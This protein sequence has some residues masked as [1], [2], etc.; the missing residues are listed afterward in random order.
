MNNK[1]MYKIGYGLYILT[2]RENSYQNGCV[3]NTCMQVTTTPN[4]ISITVNKQN[5]THDMIKESGEFNISVIS[6]KATFDLFKHFGF[7]SGANI[8]KFK[9]YKYKSKSENGIYYIT[10]FCNAFISGKVIN[11]VDLGTHTMFIA[12]VIDGDVL[13]DD[14][15]VTYEYYQNNIKPKPKPEEKHI[16]G[17]RCVICGYIYEGEELP[18]DFICPICKHGASDFVKIE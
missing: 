16:K 5:K 2:T 1:A 4:R 18:S 7:Q 14:K 11:S 17:Y 9:D 8:D 12:D 6:E 10:N 15:S 3:I 13:N